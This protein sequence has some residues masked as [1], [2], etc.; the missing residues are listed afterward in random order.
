MLSQIQPHFLYNALAVIQDMCHGKA[1]EAE[2]ATV[3]FSEFLRGNLDSLRA[4]SPI[5]FTQELRHTKCYL[6]LEKKRFGE[7]LKVEYDIGIDDFCIPALSLQ[8]IVENA[9]RY[10]VMKRVNGGTVKIMTRETEAA[11]ILQVIDDGIGFDPMQPKEDGR[12]HI[13]I[14]NVKERIRILCGGSLNIESAPGKGTAATIMLPKDLQSG[15]EK[16]SR[17]AKTSSNQSVI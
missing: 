12:T 7:N 11:Y 17:G 1:P 5:P 3:E 10:G 15:C 8:P 4:D 9:V 14:S 6:S 2:Q 16:R 13:G